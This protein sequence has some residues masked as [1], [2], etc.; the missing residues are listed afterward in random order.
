MADRGLGVK[1]AV[2]LG[3]FLTVLGLGCILLPYEDGCFL[4]LALLGIGSGLFKSNLLAAI[5]L[6]FED[7]KDPAKDKA[8]SVT[9]VLGNIGS[10]GLIFLCGFVGKLYGLPYGV[11]LVMSLF[12]VGTYLVY[13]TMRFHPSHKA[14]QASTLSQ[15]VLWGSVA[16]LVALLFFLFKYREAFHGIMGAIACGSLI[17][18]G[19]IIYGCTLLERKGMFTIVAHIFL[20]SLLVPF[21]EQSGSSVVLFLEKAVDRN[22]MD[23][24]VPSSTFLSLQ[25]LF[26]LVCG[27]LLL[28]AA[29]RL[30]KRK[31]LREFTKPGVGF[32][33]VALSFGAL[34][35]GI[36]HKSGA[37]VPFHWVI[38][39][40][41]L[42][43]FGEL[44]IVP[45]SLSKVSQH[46]PARYQSVMMSFW[47]MAIAYGHY[48]AGMVAQYSVAGNA[49]NLLGQYQAFFS[50]LGI[51][52][53]V[54][55]AL[56]L[57]LQKLGPWWLQGIGMMP[58]KGGPWLYK[59]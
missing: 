19:K 40:M 32:L 50:G 33:F 11:L 46:S 53:F 45:V 59:K 48:F 54:I 15:G 5:G 51:A 30:E 39:Y 6:A 41:F 22:V 3:G 36:A 12:A 24:T 34:A 31:P 52:A 57:L 28:F 17:Y 20:F 58:K 4:G 8:Y 25:P 1:N 55:G 56:V 14:K 37:L 47:T 21:F 27:S 29:A 44:W 38:G 43:T 26:V 2:V 35:W 23:A 18:L 42:L 49:E 16:F 9:Y 7:P 13:K 10:F